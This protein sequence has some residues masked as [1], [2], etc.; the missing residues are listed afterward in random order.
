LIGGLIEAYFNWFYYRLLSIFKIDVDKKIKEKPWLKYRSIKV[1]I[2]ILA[3]IIAILV[4]IFIVCIL[5][6]LI[7]LIMYYL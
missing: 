5:V 7:F 4:L 1:G 6:L 3:D 2:Y